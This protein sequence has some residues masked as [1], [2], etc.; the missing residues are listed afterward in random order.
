MGCSVSLIDDKTQAQFVIRSSSQS[1]NQA[2]PVG[3]E[4]LRHA[5]SHK[6]F[7]KQKAKRTILNTDRKIVLRNKSL[8]LSIKERNSKGMVENI[9]NFCW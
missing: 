3:S 1:C 6:G 9:L 7:P 8:D 5:V 4:T 2:V